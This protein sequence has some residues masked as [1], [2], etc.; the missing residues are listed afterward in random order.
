MTVQV[1]SVPLLFFSMLALYNWP[2]TRIDLRAMSMVHTLKVAKADL[3][4]SRLLTPPP[5]FSRLHLP[6]LASSHLLKPSPAF[7]G[8]L[9]RGR[10]R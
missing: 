2:K 5:A 7:S 9:P 1:M 8:A 3:A 6:P 10:R 4:F